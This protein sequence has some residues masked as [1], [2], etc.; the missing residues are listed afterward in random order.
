MGLA[1][2]VLSSSASSSPSP[3]A[4]WRRCCSCAAPHVRKKFGTARHGCHAVS[5]CSAPADGGSVAGVGGR[6]RG[7]HPGVVG[8]SRAARDDLPLRVDVSLDYR[9]SR[10]QSRCCLPPA[11]HS[12]WRRRSRPEGRPAVDAARRGPATDRSSAPHPEERADRLSG[13]GLGAAPRRHQHLPPDGRSGKS[14]PGRLCGRRR[15]DA[16]NRRTVCRLLRKPGEDRVHE[17]LRRIKAIPG[18]E[19]AALLRGLPMGG[20]SLRIVVDG[21]VDRTGSDVEAATIAAEPGFFDT[22]RIPLLYGRVFDARD[23]ADTPRS[24]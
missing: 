1:S 10:L 13:G 20:N 5:A 6:R 11:W 14:A 8:H 3:A 21:T 12:A 22:L 7:L 17:L 9:V 2:L 23:R 4:I 24:P 15:G 18:V 19:S 16:R